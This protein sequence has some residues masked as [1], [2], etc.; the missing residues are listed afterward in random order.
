MKLA[1]FDIGGTAI[2]YGCWANNELTKT[3]QFKT[4]ASYRDLKQNMQHVIHSFSNI[5][6]VALSAPGAVNIAERKIDG[7]SAVPYLHNFPIFDDLEQ[8]LGLPVAIENDANCAGICE[9]RQGAGK[10]SKNMVFI[11]IGTGVGGAIFID[12]KLYK[13]SHL[14]GGEFGLMKNWQ[15]ETF[16]A[17]GTGVKAA[18]KY[19]KLTNKQISG[20]ELFELATTDLQ[21]Q[22][23]V[24]DLYEIIANC[25][26]NLQVSLDPAIIIIGGGISAQ[27]KLIEEL[28]SRLYEKLKAERI[29]AIMPEIKACQYLNQANLIGAAHNFLLQQKK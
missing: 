7:I 12:G 25:L 17:I 2:K 5:T 21:A 19:N 9:A 16:S 1:V 24:T 28:K 4:P 15:T 6:G 10:N 27:S 23:I 29:E 20:K 14:F 3:A 18:N 26:Y 13:G 22:L 8:A 11:I